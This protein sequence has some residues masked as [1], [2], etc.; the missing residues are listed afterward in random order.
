V[1]PAKYLAAIDGLIRGGSTL[2][3][4]LIDEWGYLKLDKVNTSKQATFQ[5][6]TKIERNFC[7]ADYIS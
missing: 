2:S 5:I 3:E 4:S 1:D 6:T 7:L